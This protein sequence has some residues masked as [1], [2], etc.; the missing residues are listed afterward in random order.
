M[1][2]LGEIFSCYDLHSFRVVKRAHC[3]HITT[4]LREVCRLRN[5]ILCG[6]NIQV[7]RFLREIRL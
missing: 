2:L 1:V 4:M 7:G 5:S 3:S 6:E